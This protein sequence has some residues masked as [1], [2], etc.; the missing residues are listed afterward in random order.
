MNELYIKAVY[1]HGIHNLDY[2]FRFNGKKAIALYAPNGVMKTS[3]AKIMD[4]YRNEKPHDPNI[5]KQETP[6]LQYTNRF[7]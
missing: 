7:G 3:F 2:K 6:V 1:C 5:S 4:D